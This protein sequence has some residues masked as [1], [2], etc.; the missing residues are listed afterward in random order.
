LVEL[1]EG[2]AGEAAVVAIVP[3]APPERLAAWEAVPA[4]ELAAAPLAAPAD[5]VLDVA[6]L[7]GERAVWRCEAGDDVVLLVDTATGVARAADRASTAPA[8][9]GDATL[10][11]G[12]L[13]LLAELV[14]RAGVA[15]RG[16]LAV[17]L[18]VADDVPGGAAVR[19]E[20]SPL[21]AWH[22]ALDPAGRVDPHSS[23]S[24]PPADDERLRAALAK[25]GDPAEELAARAAGTGSVEELRRGGARRRR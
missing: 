10:A 17:V 1:G 14:G 7:A 21:A 13:D 8:R 22:V 9:I 20:M 16:S 2:L 3:G 23:W 18:G 19:T 11:P 6:R 4:V 25:S 15:D 12:A 5:A 24:D